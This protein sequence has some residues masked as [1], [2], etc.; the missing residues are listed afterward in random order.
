MPHQCVRCNTIYD[1][2][3]KEILKGCNCGGKLFFYIKKKRLE[4]LK[5][6]TTKL[7]KKDKKQI[8]EDVLELVG[9]EKID[10]DQPVILDFESIRIL[11]PGQYELDLVHLFKKQPLVYKL[12]EGKYVID[13]PVTFGQEKER[14]E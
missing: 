10:Q 13:L 6:T 8:E 5:E 1:D 12:E 11:K 7:T 4:E 3:A 2:T 9:K 14:I